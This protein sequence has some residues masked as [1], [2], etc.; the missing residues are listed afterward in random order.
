M[1]LINPFAMI[2][3]TRENFKEL[4]RGLRDLE[5]R[6]TAENAEANEQ[7]YNPKL[8]DFKLEASI[9][10]DWN[11]VDVKMIP[12][13]GLSGD[14]VKD[15]IEELEVTYGFETIFVQG[16]FEFTADLC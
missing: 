14:N 9:N 8:I 4:L 15:I 1:N 12:F 6:I 10:E 13:V 7:D 3:I 16:E 2:T 5:Q 11:S